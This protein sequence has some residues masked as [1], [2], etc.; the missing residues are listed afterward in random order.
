MFEEPLVVSIDCNCRHARGRGKLLG[1][2]I[3]FPS[4]ERRIHHIRKITAKQH[5]I[6][7]EAVA[8]MHDTFHLFAVE[9]G[10][11]MEVAQKHSREL[12]FRRK[13]HLEFANLE[14]LVVTHTNRQEHNRHHD[15]NKKQKSRHRNDKAA[16]N[17]LLHH[18][19]ANT[20]SNPP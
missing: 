4:R 9:Q 17:R 6:R 13:C 11:N 15:R 2:K 10:V 1:Q 8:H 14:V 20:A 3:V 18:G 16:V 5:E 19:T 12:V 7:M